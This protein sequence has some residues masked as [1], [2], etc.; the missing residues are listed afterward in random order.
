VRLED[1][2]WEIASQALC[3]GLLLLVIEM[4]RA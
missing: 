4:N 3:L 2:R 1:G